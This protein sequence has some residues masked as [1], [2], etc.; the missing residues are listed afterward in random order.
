MHRLGKSK[1]PPEEDDAESLSEV[2]KEEVSRRIWQQLATQDW[3]SVPFAE[4]YCTPTMTNI[5]FKLTA[6]G[7]NPLHFNTRSSQHVDEETMR[8]IPFSQ[9]SFVDFGNFFFRI[10]SLMPALLDRYY[11]A[12]TLDAK[13]EHVLRFDKM[14]RELV[15]SQLPTYLYSQTP[16][17][18]AWPPWVVLARRALSISAAHK[19]IMIHRRFLGMSFHDKRFDFTRRTCLAAAK[20]IINEMKQDDSDK[21]PIFWTIQAFS[22]AAGIILS[23]DNF[24]RHQST[25][26]HEENRQLITETISI[27]SK[28]VY[29]SSIAARG[30]RLLNELLAEDRNHSQAGVNGKERANDNT[31]APRKPEKTLNVAAFVKKFCEMEMPPSAEKLPIPAEHIPLWLQQD[32]T[33]QYQYGQEMNVPSGPRYP[34]YSLKGQQAYGMD[35]GYS[36]LRRASENPFSLVADGFDISSVTWFDDLSGL[37]PSHSI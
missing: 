11:E 4:T 30:T 10:A 9:P 21:N 3:F 23:L 17:D 19:I 5:K 6:S 15:L 32:N 13:Y 36:N 35:H 18:P 8:P 22:V 14:T 1:G 37:A 31:S 20:T 29:I 24:N 7:I 2:V 28:S 27:L 33:W 16:V 25:R 34:G 26:E 12:P